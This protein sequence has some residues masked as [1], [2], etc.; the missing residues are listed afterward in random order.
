MASRQQIEH[1]GK[2]GEEQASEQVHAIETA[3]RFAQR[4]D[5]ILGSTFAN[6]AWD[7][8]LRLYAA[9]L[10][11]SGVPLAALTGAEGRSRAS[12]RWID[13][14][15]QDGLVMT[16]SGAGTMV[17]LTPHGKASMDTLFASARGSAVDAA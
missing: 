2:S 6:P 3:L 12:E 17:S 9:M 4:R 11:G 14:L 5:L 8:M 7:I 15:V 1:I 13:A 10:E 16:Q